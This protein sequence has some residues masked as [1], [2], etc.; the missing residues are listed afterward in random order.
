MNELPKSS[1]KGVIQS[2]SRAFTLLEAIA[3]EP[4]GVGLTALSKS[5]G[6]HSSTVFHL[7]KTMVGMGYLR[8][9]PDNKNYFIGPQVF[10]LAASARSE[11]ALV[12]AADPVL[13]ELALTTGDSCLFGIRAIDDVAIVVGKAEGNAVFQISDRLGGARPGHCTGMGKVLLAFLPERRLEPYLRTHELKAFTPNT[14]TDRGRLKAEL[15]EIQRTGFACDDAE[16]H[17]DLRCI[18]APVRD[19]THQVIGALALSGPSWR[20]SMQTL[21]ARSGL[22][23]KAA[24]EVS[25]LLG[26][27]GE[28][29]DAV[30][31][32]KRYV[33]KGKR[34][35][36]RHTVHP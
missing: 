33:R 12:R 4:H 6:L 9:G 8:Q 17:P 32:K 10:C 19:F 21:Q 27:Q 30:S 15:L 25:A 23:R 29:S 14:I 26:Y 34:N 20:L 3:N 13:R 2:L 7:L 16:F 18:A 28:Q 1:S 22:L 36:E 24:D 31:A 11:L 35:S 5:T